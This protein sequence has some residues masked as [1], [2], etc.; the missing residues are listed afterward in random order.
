[1]KFRVSEKIPWD[2]LHTRAGQLR[3]GQDYDSDELRLSPERI[4]Y[5]RGLHLGQIKV[6]EELTDQ[7]GQS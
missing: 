6:I 7:G 3:K 1:M 4:E 2:N 5:L